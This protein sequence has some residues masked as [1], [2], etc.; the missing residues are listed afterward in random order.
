LVVAADPGD[1]FAPDPDTMWRAVLRRQGGKLS[2]LADF[3]AHPSL[4]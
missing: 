1:V 2:M 4:N 3:P